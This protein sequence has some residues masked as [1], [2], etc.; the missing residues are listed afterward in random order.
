MG[1]ASVTAAIAAVGA[2][3]IVIVTDDE[4]RENEGD[5][6]MASEAATPEKIAFFLRHTSGVLCAAITKERADNLNL[7]MMVEQNEESQQTAFTVTVDLAHGITTGISAS[8]RASTLVALADPTAGPTR[9]VRPGHILPLRARNGGV[10]KRAG[11]TEAAVDL[12]RLAG[13]QAAGTISEVVTGDKLGM[14][15]GPELARLA[16]QHGLVRTSIASLIRYR[17]SS[18]SL[19]RQIA[20]ARVPTRHGEFVCYVWESM[21]DGIEHVALV[22]GDVCGSEPVLVRV[23]SEC[24]TGDVFGSDRCDCG[25]QL[26]DALRAINEVGSGVVVYL[27]GHEGRGIGL[28]R[29]LQAYNLQDAGLDTVDA[30]LRLGLPVDS[31]EYGVGAQI[32]MDLGIQRIRL[33]T[34]N[35]DKYAGLSGYGLE[36]TERVSVTPRV[37]PHNL[38]YLRTKRDRLGHL[39]PQKL[40]R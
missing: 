25:V 21:L 32:L 24:L 16:A 4:S 39:L 22:K 38:E 11:H 1:I 29:K 15:Q 20:S 3:E 37:T 6:I 10:L 14:A 28:S 2:G 33:M 5:L 23:H 19:I 9:F 18:E 31:R 8:D 30:N 12:A 7:P 13:L 17:L 27:R 36:I 34:N 26:D 35:P 40:S